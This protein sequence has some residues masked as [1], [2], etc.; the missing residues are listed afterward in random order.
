MISLGIL[1][2]PLTKTKNVHLGN[3]RMLVEDL[4]MLREKTDG[5]LNGDEKAHLDKVIGDL[6]G[7]MDRLSSD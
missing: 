4:R 3:A 6:V 7:V 5:N 1:E 2:N